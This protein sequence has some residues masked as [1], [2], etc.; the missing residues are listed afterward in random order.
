MAGSDWRG[1]HEAELGLWQFLGD[2]DL[3]KTIGFRG[4]QPG[5]PLR[6]ALVNPRVVKVV[7]DSDVIWLRILDP[8]A[9]LALRGYDADGSLRLGVTDPMGYAAGTYAITVRDGVVTV[10]RVADDADNADV[11]ID[12]E[13]LG[14]CY[15]GL[16]SPMSLL[17][18]GRVAGPEDAVRAFTRLF[19]TDRAAHNVT[20][21]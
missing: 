9:A 8:E 12:V 5:S 16:V 19:A 21:F 15:F 6:H 20:H 10:E 17:A 14:S 3:V 4:W 1:H 7:G 2:I 11:T 18:A 13:A